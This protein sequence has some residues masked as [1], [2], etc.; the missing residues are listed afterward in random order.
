MEDL[1]E[2]E[3]ALKKSAQN[4]IRENFTGCK[5]GV[6]IVVGK[7][8]LHN[9]LIKGQNPNGISIKVRRLKC[10]NSEGPA[11]KNR[12]VILCQFDQVTQETSSGDRTFLLAQCFRQVS[13]NIENFLMNHIDANEYVKKTDIS[14]CTNIM[15]WESHIIDWYSDINSALNREF[16]QA[17]SAENF[18]MLALESWNFGS[19]DDE[20]IW[21]DR[22]SLMHR[23]AIN[24]IRDRVLYK[25]IA[26]AIYRLNA[27]CR[28]A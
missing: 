8:Q 6:K 20:E 25:T 22:Y 19:D 12:Y 10:N 13:K 17:A 1:D 26:A 28:C 3:S 2:I 11:L 15:S 21:S 5:T 9:V 4:V 27:G 16:P 23:N 14:F 24:N 7:S 18:S